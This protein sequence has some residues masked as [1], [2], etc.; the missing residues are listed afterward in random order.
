[1]WN[2]RTLVATSGLALSIGVAANVPAETVPS[3][4]VEGGQY[5]AVLNQRTQAWRLLPGDGI[6]L[7]VSAAESGCRAGGHLPE[8]IWL[9]TS[10]AEGRPVLTAPSFTELPAD[11]PQ[12]VALRACGAPADGQPH[13]AAPQGL[14]D[15]LTYNTGAIYVED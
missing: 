7:A 8:G 1:M 12:Q 5:T 3:V 13:V 2:L 14:I 15:W 10:D 6:D 11:H 9:V 4:Y